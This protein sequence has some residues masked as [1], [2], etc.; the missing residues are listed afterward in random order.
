MTFYSRAINAIGFESPPGLLD[1]HFPSPTSDIILWVHAHP[2][3]GGTLTLALQDLLN[4]RALNG[5]CIRE[6][7]GTNNHCGLYA[8]YQGFA[9]LTIMYPELFASPLPSLAMVY[10]WMVIDRRNYWRYIYLHRDIFHHLLFDMSDFVPRHSF[11]GPQL[12]LLTYWLGEQTGCTR[13]VR[14]IWLIQ[15][16][17]HSPNH[18]IFSSRPGVPLDTTSALADV[19]IFLHHAPGNIATDTPPH[20]RLFSGSPWRYAIQENAAIMHGGEPTDAEFNWPFEQAARQAREASISIRLNWHHSNN[21]P[22]ACLLAWDFGLLSHDPNAHWLSTMPPR[23]PLTP[24]QMAPLFG[25]AAGTS[26]VRK[27]ANDWVKGVRR[28]NTLEAQYLVPVRGNVDQS[29]LEVALRT[30]FPLVEF[31]HYLAESRHMR[32]AWILLDPVAL[33]FMLDR[34]RKG[35]LSTSVYFGGGAGDGTSASVGASNGTHGLSAG[36]GASNGGYSGDG[37]SEE[38]DSLPVSDANTI[39]TKTTLK[40]RKGA[41]VTSTSGRKRSKKSSVGTSQSHVTKPSQLVASTKADQKQRP[42][43]VTRAMTKSF[44]SLSDA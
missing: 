44:G 8:V 1:I 6:I 41:G 27:C 9:D 23:T 22:S 5:F 42:G 11:T 2:L 7:P 17:C 32:Y 25:L 26:S 15:E 28:N 14:N 3:Y 33:R 20:W 31:A 19:Y 12:D 43:P 21:L 16:S 38:E 30:H 4:L 10:D 35:D 36:N 24:L 13:T 29:T 37:L 34:T 18:H 40:K 39:T